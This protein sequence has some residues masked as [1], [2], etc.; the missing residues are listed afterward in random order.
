MTKDEGP[1]AEIERLEA[2]IKAEEDEKIR[3]LKELLENSPEIAQ[4]LP[5]EFAELKQLI[6]EYEGT[7]V[8]DETI[9]KTYLRDSD[10][11]VFWEV[12]SEGNDV[13]V[14]SGAVGSDGEQ[15][16]TSHDSHAIAV[17]AM[18]QQILAKRK[19]GYN[20]PDALSMKDLLEYDT[21]DL[22]DIDE[23]LY[24]ELHED[25]GEVIFIDGDLA[26]SEDLDLDHLMEESEGE[27][28][29]IIVTGNLR[30]DGGIDNS[31]GDYGPFLIVKG[32]TVADH[33]IGGGSEIYLEKESV[34]YTLM[35]GHYNHGI[36]SAKGFALFFLN[37][38]HHSEV[39]VNEV[40]GLSDNHFDVNSGAFSDVYRNIDPD[41]PDEDDDDYYI[42]I[43]IINGMIRVEEDRLKLVQQLLEAFRG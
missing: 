35:I 7:A 13:L 2:E 3:Q 37:D 36:L 20:S 1:L 11:K 6:D 8:Y 10:G 27:I 5:E 42:D 18:Y 30:V 31:E 38:I 28:V 41:E 15:S 40:A 12:W 21:V 24:E 32:R 9:I 4:H 29:G 26:I 17:F 19:E 33:V 43:E 14:R 25:E 23:E 16:T 34:I 22:E 39:K